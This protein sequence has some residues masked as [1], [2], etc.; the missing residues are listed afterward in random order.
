LFTHSDWTNSNWRRRC[1]PMKTNINPR[2]APSSSN[3]PSGR[4][5][6]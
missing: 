3:T 4:G 5:G 2:S 6:P 1:A